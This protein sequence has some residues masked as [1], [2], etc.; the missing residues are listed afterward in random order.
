[1]RW[2]RVGAWCRVAA[3]DGAGGGA[4]EVPQAYGLGGADTCGLDGSV[5]TVHGVDV[6][7]VVAAGHVLYPA[8]KD[9]MCLM[10]SWL[11]LA[12]SKR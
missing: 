1:L 3:G 11:A 8:D 9:S 7:W 5:L 4:R 10:S 12:P 2:R 6:L